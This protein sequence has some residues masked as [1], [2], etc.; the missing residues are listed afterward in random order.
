[1]LYEGCCEKNELKS[2]FIITLIQ[3]T[4]EIT[5]MFGEGSPLLDSDIIA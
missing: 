4:F 5:K 3:S 1:M 2:S